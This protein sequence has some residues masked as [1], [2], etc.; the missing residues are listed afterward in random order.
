MLQLFPASEEQARAGG[1]HAFEGWEY[2]STGSTYHPRSA[3]AFTWNSV[4]RMVA[5]APFG[6]IDMIAPRPLLMIVGTEAVTKWMSTQAFDHALEP[7]E[8]FW[9][10]DATHVGLYDKAEPV[11]RA[12][13]ELGSLFRERLGA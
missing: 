6:L 2:Y 4:D 12:T 8:L 1:L 3:K 7:K 10:K 5:F 11:S 13:S 9:I